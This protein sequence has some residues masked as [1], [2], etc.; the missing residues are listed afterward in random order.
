MAKSKELTKSQAVKDYL[1]AHPK[2]MSSEIAA[3]LSDQGIDIKPG[4][5]SN[6]KTKLKARRSSRKPAAATAGMGPEIVAPAMAE[7]PTRSGEG[8]TIEQIKAVGQMVKMVGGFDRFREMLDVVRQIG[9][10]K[11][12]RDIVDAMAVGSTDGIPF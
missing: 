8:I 2:A 6:I 12:F 10:L 3:A 5:V 11:R 4:Y 9:G 7:T 1:K